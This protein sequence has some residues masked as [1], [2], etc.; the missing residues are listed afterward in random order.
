MSTA[1]ARDTLEAAYRTE[2]RRVLATLIRLLGGFEAAEETQQ[3]ATQAPVQTPA[4]G[5]TPLPGTV[6]N[7]GTGGAPCPICGTSAGAAPSSLCF[8]PDGLPALGLRRLPRMV[9]SH[10][11]WTPPPPLWSGRGSF[12]RWLTTLCCRSRRPLTL[13][14][15]E[16]LA[17]LGGGEFA[18]IRYQRLVVPS[19]RASL[20]LARL[21]SAQSGRGGRVPS[22]PDPPPPLFAG[23]RVLRR[24]LKLSPRKARQ[25]LS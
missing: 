4:P 13:V 12:G 23:P 24:W 5:A 16:V 2:A 19:P 8:K 6:G 17:W 20:R 22:R 15:V 3:I 14:D 9:G 18:P 11:D 10:P 21:E 1:G 25:P 7:G